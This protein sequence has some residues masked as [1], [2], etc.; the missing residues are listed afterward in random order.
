MAT[1]QELLDSVADDLDPDID[2]KAK[3]LSGG[4]RTPNAVRQGDKADLERACGLLLGDATVIWKAAGGV[5]GRQ[6]PVR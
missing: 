4:Y 1:L 5:S 3:L 2:Y 6:L